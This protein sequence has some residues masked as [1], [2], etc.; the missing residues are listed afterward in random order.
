MN[1]EVEHTSSETLDRYAFPLPTIEQ[2]Q[3]I[4]RELDWGDHFV[5]IEMNPAAG[6]RDIYIYSLKEAV[7]FLR[8]GTAG[9]GL[10]TGAKASISWFKIDAFV[11]WIRT[12]VQDEALADAIAKDTESESAYHG[13]VQKLGAVLDL[14]YSQLIDVVEMAKGQAEEAAG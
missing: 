5:G 14:R 7:Q 1:T 9:M 13:K 6:N 3:H 10:S 12:K 11:D 8:Y 2:A 4:L